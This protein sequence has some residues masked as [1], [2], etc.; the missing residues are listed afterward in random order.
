M[1]SFCV[2]PKLALATVVQ[3]KSRPFVLNTLKIIALILHYPLL[4]LDE[5][6]GSLKGRC[7]LLKYSRRGTTRTHRPS[8]Y[9]SFQD[10]FLRSGGCFLARAGLKRN[11]QSQSHTIIMDYMM[12][13]KLSLSLTLS[14]FL[15]LSISLSSKT[16]PEI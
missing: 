6:V 16:G 13:T 14:P 3:K 9:G 4:T 15:S 1:G 8:V 7:R 5:A 11:S 12:V 2:H 10:V